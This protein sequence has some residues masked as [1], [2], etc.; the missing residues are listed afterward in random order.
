MASSFTTSFGIEKIATGEQ[1]GVWGT[2][3]NHNADILDRIA[4]Y[5]SVALSGTTHTLTVREAS[6]GAGT[7]NLQDGMYRVIKFTGALGANNTVTIAPNTSKAWFI[8]ENATTDS[9]SSGPYSVILTQGS[10]ANITLQNGKNAIVYCDGAGGGAVVFNALNDLQIATLEVTGA[11]A[12]DGLLTAGASVAVTGNVTTTGT[13]EPAG[14]TAAADNAAIGYTAGEGLILTG[15]GSTNDVTIKND[16][17]G[18]VMGVLTGST[19]AAFTGQVTATGFT[20]TLD[21]ILGSG[22]AAAVS[23]TTID[24]SGKV[25]AAAKLD[26]NG[27]EIILDADADTSITADTD[28]QIDIRIAG[29]DDFQFTA[30]TFTALSGSTVAIASGATIANS[31]TATGFGAG[32]EDAYAGVLEANAN[33]NDQVIF[34]PS[35]DGQSWNGAWGKASLFSSLMLCTVETAGS[36]TQ[37]NIWDLTEQ[38]SGAIST[39]PL[40]TVTISGVTPRAVDAAMGYIIIATDG[41]AK[42]VDPHDGSWAQRTSGWPKSLS[43]ATTPTLTNSD[44][45]AVAAGLSSTSPLDPRTGGPLPVFACAY[46][47]GADVGSLIKYDGNVFDLA[48]TIGPE[49]VVGFVDDR[50]ALGRSNS[51]DQLLLSSTTIDLIVADDWSAVAY[52]YDGNAQQFYLGANTAA[53]FHNADSVFADTTGLTIRRNDFIGSTGAAQG[54]SAMVTRAF[55]SG[56]L[57]NYTKGAWLANSKTVDRSGNSNTLTENGTVT[58]GVV[59]TSAELKGYSGFS[60]STNY[61][62]R[63]FDADLDF[64]TANFSA[65]IWF[66]RTAT[67]GTQYL[68]ARKSTA[69]GGSNIFCSLASGAHT[70]RMFI[71]DGSNAAD[72]SGIAYTGSVW[73]QLVVVWDGTLGTNSVYINGVLKNTTTNASVGTLTNSNATLAVGATD[74]GTSALDQGSVSLFRLSATAPTAT[75]IRQMYD[76]EKGMFVASAECLLQSG[77]TDAVLDVDVD[78]LSGKVLVTQTDA[79][80]VFDGLV[81][82]SKPTVNSGASEKGKLWGALR[83]EQNSAN[84]YV[85]APATDQRQVNEMVRGLASEL[86]KGVDLSKAKAWIQFD[87]ESANTIDGSF[88]VKSVTDVGTGDYDIYW[89][90][91]FKSNDYVVVATS[92][93]PVSMAYIQRSGGVSQIFTDSVT[94]AVDDASG[95]ANARIFVVAFGEL[96]NE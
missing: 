56:F 23:G 4:S 50:I 83:A 69:S 55:N 66:K 5:T 15:Q 46:G 64:G 41:G 63:A 54:V 72:N 85:T 35:V 80:T 42:M 37:V 92:G 89:G 59:E 57:I 27:T 29:A 24:A 58:E 49:N 26:M 38:S 7:E 33:F 86:P 67:S 76:A 74:N 91:P 44:V 20:G 3:T 10:G 82:D 77:S 61:L 75:Q 53:T 9:G 18:E 32:T 22:T 65:I 81:V 21:G 12:V 34:G 19:T 6:P 39:T 79:I 17:D 45:T 95:A 25:T 11:A 62:S 1:A 43:T 2:T 73:N 31:G 8:V 84:A 52:A 87:G 70:L 93:Y 96:E 94:V 78:P 36:D 88:N 13:V 68:W 60:D 14:D 90:I 28:D 71:G 47:T 51:G 30:N 16:A 48:G 40:G